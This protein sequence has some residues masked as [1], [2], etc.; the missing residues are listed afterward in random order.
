MTNQSNYSSFGNDF[1]SPGLGIVEA[2]PG[3]FYGIAIKGGDHDQ[4]GIWKFDINVSGYNKVDD[5]DTIDNGV[6]RKPNSPLIIGP[7]GDLYGVLIYRGQFGNA[8]DD[9]H[10]YKVN[11]STQQ[12]EYVTNLSTAGWAIEGP[13]YQIC[14]N[15]SLNKIFG[16]KELFSGLNFGGG[17]YS[18][19][20]NTQEVTNA[21]SILIGEIDIL[22]SNA[23]GM[24][25]QANDGNHYFVTRNGGAH[26]MGTLVKFVPG[27]NT[28][29]KV[30]DFTQQVNGTGLVVSGTKIYG[31]YDEINE[32]TPMV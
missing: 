31:S 13:I 32:N 15:S 11:L 29:A 28:M 9:G 27:Q 26:G 2:E 5:F 1:L 19:D 12:L 3:V 14:Y 10:L 25:P 17:V 4:G 30:Y 18:Y 23:N 7:N 24:T 8:N 16:T 20:F 22:G 21:S 6:G